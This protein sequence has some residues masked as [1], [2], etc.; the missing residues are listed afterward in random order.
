VFRLGTRIEH[1]DT[2]DH[3]HLDRAA[4]EV[5][6]APSVE[7]RDSDALD[8]LRESLEVVVDEQTPNDGSRAA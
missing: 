7:L 1:S 4:S 8:F 5:Q 3:A 6:A 2:V